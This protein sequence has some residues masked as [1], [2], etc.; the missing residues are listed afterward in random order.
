[1]R[2]RRK[3]CDN[4][5]EQRVHIRRLRLATPLH[6]TRARDMADRT[7]RKVLELLAATGQS[8]RLAD[9]KVRVTPEEGSDPDRLARRIV[10]EI[11]RRIR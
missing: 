9:L 7:A 8:G 3:G 10:A 1:M 11:C 4:M 6:K 2:E 5:S